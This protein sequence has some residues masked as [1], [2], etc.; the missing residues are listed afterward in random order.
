MKITDSIDHMR[1]SE[2]MLPQHG[3]GVIP[4]NSSERQQ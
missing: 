1:N 2:A 3:L 4:A